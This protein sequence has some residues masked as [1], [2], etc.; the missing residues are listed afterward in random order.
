[1]SAV[2]KKVTT[3]MQEIYVRMF[4]SRLRSM[5]GDSRNVIF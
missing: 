2:P 3:E 1:M 5:Y 4:V